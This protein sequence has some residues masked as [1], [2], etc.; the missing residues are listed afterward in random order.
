MINSVIQNSLQY[1][2]HKLL[3]GGCVL[4]QKIH[5]KILADIPILFLIY[6]V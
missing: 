3:Y 4:C 5:S 6:S 2:T 1:F